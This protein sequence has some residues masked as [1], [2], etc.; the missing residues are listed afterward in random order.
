MAS[1]PVA[2]SRIG[3]EYGYL[4]VLEVGGRNRRGDV[5]LKCRCRCGRLYTGAGCDIFSLSTV[6]CGCYRREKATRHGMCGTP[7]YRSWQHV[8]DRCGNVSNKDY[9][10]YGG[11]GIAVCPEWK[12]F[13]Q[14]YADMGPRPSP[15]HS[16]DRKDNNGN[17]CK[18]NCRW[19]TRKEQHNNQRSNKML[20]YNGETRTMSQWAEEAG[21]SYSA[22]RYRLI[23]GWSVEKALTT[24]VKT[25][26]SK[27][28]G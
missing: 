3:K 15:K 21:I 5:I 2:Y 14:F 22:L 1:V 4:T 19:A 28:G 11:R 8:L 24:P 13:E 9:L 27:V 26:N 16:I 17:Y 18:E 23:R 20:T 6:S 12:S 7:E 10:H 25:K